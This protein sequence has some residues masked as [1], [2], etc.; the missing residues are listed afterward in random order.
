MTPPDFYFL[1]PDSDLFMPMTVDGAFRD[2]RASHDIVVLASLAPDVTL[3][4][5]QV[6]MDRIT[7]NLARAHPATNDGWRTRLVPVFPLNRGL[8][9]AFMVLLA[10]VGCVL[11]IACLNVAGLLLV[12]GG[13]RQREIALRASLGASRSRLVRQMLT[14]SALLAFIGATAGVGL[15]AGALRFL[16]P[17]MPTVQVTQPLTLTPDTRVLAFTFGVAAITTVACGLLPAIRS[18][19]TQQ[20]RVGAAQ[21]GHRP[22]G[23]R[24]VLAVEIA[25][26]LMLLVGAVLLVRSLWHLQRV[27]PG[28]RAD[29]LLTM[30][31]WLPE[32]KYEGASEVAG[33]S[34]EILRRFAQ[35]PEVSAAATVNTRPFLGWSLLMDVDIPEQPRPPN[36]E[37]Q[38]VAYR[39]ISPGYLE[40]LGI[41]LIRGRGFDD[42]DGPRNAPVALVN[43]A[44]VRRFWPD[45]DPVGAHLRTPVQETNV[46][47]WTPYRSADAY[48]VVGVVGDTREDLLRDTS[49]PVV[50]LEHRQNPSRFMHLLVRTSVRPEA[51][52]DLVQSQIREVDPDLGVYDLRSMDAILSDVVAQPRLNS[53]L[54]WVFAG[55][56]LLLSA[57]GVYGVSSYAVSQRRREFAIRLALGAR[58]ASVFGMVTRESLAVGAIG[59]AAGLGGAGLL[60]RA[61]SNVL[62]G[63]AANDVMTLVGAAAVV[64][65]VTLLACWQPARK[66]AGVDPMT[67][68]RTE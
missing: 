43:E 38:F 11:L 62:Y 44:M 21:A 8:R 16:A 42:A 60:G 33:F 65:G 40:T 24:S 25:L 54:L 32:T 51:V 55:V 68:L 47:P 18:S 48:R 4:E 9:P 6:E 23:G 28:F 13:V 67:A 35:F 12:R 36:V 66:A 39:I 64:L 14:E 50:Y 57:V 22:A 52:S 1:W 19:R 37:R 58:P 41:P 59:V 20:L 34:A 15:S 31:L 45:R 5:A 27:D 29:G 26:S 63:V 61:L 2:A 17:L 53:L 3:P 10:A 49:Q 46:G 30:Q 56:A 7:A